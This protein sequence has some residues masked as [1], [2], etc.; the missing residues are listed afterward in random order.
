M[1][2]VSGRTDAGFTLLEILLVIVIMAVT[3][4][5]VAP[6]Y[7]SAVSVSIDDEGKR[8]AQVLRLASEEATLSGNTF[9]VRFRKHSYQF[10]SA[11]QEGAWQTLQ[12]RPYQ[13]YQLPEGFQVVEI[14]PAVPLTEDVDRETKGTEPVLADVLLL[15]EGISQ[16]ADIVL[17]TEPAN[18][19]QL[20]VRLR[21]GP[22]GIHVEKASDGQ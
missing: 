11:D 1:N 2:R 12:D 13:P 15:P 8:L 3:S 10:Q 19:R 4:M 18:G 17:A 5:M 7:F 6:S 22:G 9:R 16:I 20:I 21:P 14:R